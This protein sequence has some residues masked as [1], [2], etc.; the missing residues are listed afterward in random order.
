MHDIEQIQVALNE[1]TKILEEEKQRLSEEIEEKA[2]SYEDM[3]RAVEVHQA[4]E[5]ELSEVV[6]QLE[7]EKE[8]IQIK[9]AE[10]TLALGEQVERLKKEMTQSVGLEMEEKISGL[11]RTIESCEVS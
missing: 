7:A 10:E 11:L 3:K 8:V 4:N 1:Q 2:H 9:L 6:K 5:V